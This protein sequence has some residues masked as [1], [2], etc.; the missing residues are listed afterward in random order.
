MSNEILNDQIA[1]LK[2]AL[3]SAKAENSALTDRLAEANV[4]KYE[5]S[6]DKLKNQIQTAEENL[7]EKATELEVASSSLEEL[8]SKFESITEAHEKLENHISEMEAAE[9]TR[10]R[11]SSLIE[12]GLSDEEAE[13]KLETFGSLN[14]EQFAALAETIA[15]YTQTIDTPDTPTDGD[16]GEGFVHQEDE[17]KK[18]KKKHEEDEDD[19]DASEEAEASEEKSD[20]EVLETAQAEEASALSVEADAS[21]GGDDEVDGVR[22]SLQDWVQTVILDHNNSESGE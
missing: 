16:T 21:V 20:E 18:K 1:E 13:A 5:K 8:T 2:N 17:K 15:I 22:A 7:S 3:E 19:S 9:K 10:A 12:A 6:I 11:K 4:E 14:D